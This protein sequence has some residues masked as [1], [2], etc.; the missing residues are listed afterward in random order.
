[1]REQRRVLHGNRGVDAR[2]N[3]HEVA[4]QR[5]LAAGIGDHHRIEEPR[6][7]GEALHFTG[8]RRRACLPVVAEATAR[9]APQRYLEVNQHRLPNRCEPRV[10]AEK[11]RNVPGTKFAREH[12][13]E[14]IEESEIAENYFA[15]EAQRRREGPKRG[16]AKALL[17]E[18]SRA[19][20]KKIPGV[21][22]AS[23]P[24]RQSSSLLSLTLLERYTNA[25]L[26]SCSKSDLVSCISVAG[27][28]QPG[29]VSEHAL[30]PLAHLR[31]A[32]G[33]DHL[34]RMQRV[35]DPNAAAVMERHP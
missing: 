2:D 6:C 11:Y 17:A 25:M 16:T 4:P 10:L 3:V 26:L 21:L 23:E 13:G 35:A 22:C 32:V 27:H 9:V 1:M 19:V 5:R 29:I 8:A 15:A 12:F 33:D 18:A 28:T 24:L 7:I 14:F 34:S 31:R 30:E 20:R